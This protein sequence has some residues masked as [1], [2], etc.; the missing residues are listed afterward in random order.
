LRLSSP[1]EAGNSHESR[2]FWLSELRTS[3]S[4]KSLLRGE[5]HCPSAAVLCGPWDPPRQ[6]N[7]TVPMTCRPPPRSGT[8]PDNIVLQSQDSPCPIS[9]DT[10][11]RYNLDVIRSEFAHTRRLVRIAI[12]PELREPSPSLCLVEGRKRKSVANSVVSAAPQCGP[13]S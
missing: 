3:T 1:G 7:P 9:S 10:R 6:R 8:A 13:A 2:V 11:A 5:A 4:A 12:G